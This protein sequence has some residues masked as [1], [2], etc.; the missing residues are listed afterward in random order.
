VTLR[1]ED[2]RTAG[3]PVEVTADWCVCTIP[4]SILG[5]MEHNLPSD[6][7]NLVATM[8][9]EGSVKFGLK[10]NRRFLE[11]YEISRSPML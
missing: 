4:F 9:Y 2:T 5:Q 8:Y 3:A 1:Y 6:K 7:S 11:E 10:F